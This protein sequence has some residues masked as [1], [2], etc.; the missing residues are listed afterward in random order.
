MEIKNIIKSTNFLDF[1]NNMDDLALEILYDP[2]SGYVNLTSKRAIDEAQ[3]KLK[4]FD[5]NIEKLIEKTNLDNTDKIIKEKREFLISVIKKHYKEQAL[6]WCDEVY[7]NSMENCKTIIALNKD[8][9]Q[10]A[11]NTFQKAIAMISWLSDIKKLSTKEENILFE[12]FNKELDEIIKSNGYK[13]LKPRTKSDETVFLD[14]FNKIKD[15]DFTNMDINSYSEDLTRYD[16]NY[17]KQIQTDLSTY[18]STSIKDEIDIIQGAFSILNL[19]DNKEKYEFLKEVINDFMS[20]KAQN[21]KLSQ[22][23][24][25]HLIKHRV[26]I[27]KDRIN[28]FKNQIKTEKG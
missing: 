3:N 27:F 22:E 8:N 28:Y 18:K 11:D 9:K 5:E 4:Y 26:L 13:L 21:K 16:L 24:K 25:I 23:D 7:R 19:K 20:F 6:V 12:Q 14:L 17:F 10:I 2:D 1:V 15:R